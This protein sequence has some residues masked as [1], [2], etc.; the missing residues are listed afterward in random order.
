MLPSPP[1]IEGLKFVFLY[2]PFYLESGSKSYILDWATPQ[3]KKQVAK[4]LMDNDRNKR[5]I[6]Q[7]FTHSKKKVSGPNAKLP[8]N[9][10][11]F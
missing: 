4:F 9:A 7:T 1:G 5:P 10:I 3:I 6:F 8:I 2:D 11:F